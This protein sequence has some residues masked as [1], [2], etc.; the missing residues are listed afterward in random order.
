MGL[1]PGIDNEIAYKYLHPSR[2][3]VLRDNRIRF[4]QPAALN[5]PFESNP[6]GDELRQ[7]LID[8][9]KAILDH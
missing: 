7:S 6:I 9:Q 4:T 5:D 2:I 8:N 1:A 3:D